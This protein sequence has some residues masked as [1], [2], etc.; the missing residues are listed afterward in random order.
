MVD[1]KI[2]EEW[3]IIDRWWTIMPQC[4]E[5]IEVEWWGNRRVIF[6]RKEGEHIWRIHKVG[7]NYV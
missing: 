7:N 3:R 1:V 4:R 2:I 6:W 5:Y